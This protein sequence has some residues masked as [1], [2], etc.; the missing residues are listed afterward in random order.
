YDNHGKLFGAES[1][2]RWHSV[3]LGS[4]SPVECIPEA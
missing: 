2:L 1:L 4:V 3:P